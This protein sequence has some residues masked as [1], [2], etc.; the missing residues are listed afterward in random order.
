MQHATVNCLASRGISGI[1]IPLTICTFILVIKN[2]HG[3]FLLF[4]L[5]ASTYPGARTRT[6]EGERKSLVKDSPM[7]PCGMGHEQQARQYRWFES[8]LSLGKGSFCCC[9]FTYQARERIGQTHSNNSYLLTMAVWNTTSYEHDPRWTAVDAY[10][11][12]HLHPKDRP[13][14]PSLDTTLE[15]IRASGLPDDSTYPA[16]RKFLA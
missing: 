16:F 14:A 15:D 11:V 9:H 6:V 7:Y 2:V 8:R 4:S 13:Y 10:G 5:A 3:Q 1:G 12:S